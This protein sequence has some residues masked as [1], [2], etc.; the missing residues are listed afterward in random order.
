V[1]YAMGSGIT[2]ESI[3]TPRSG[4]PFLAVTLD[5]GERLLVSP[6]RV[7][8]LAAGDELDA[9][10]AR[11]LRN[12]AY[13]DRLEARLLRL[14][15]VRWRSRGELARRL[16]AWGTPHA[17]AEQLLVRLERRGLLDEERLAGQVSRD[18]RRRGHGSRR[19]AHDLE[20]LEVDDE[21]ATEIV[22]AHER[23]DT[24][25]ATQLILER[26][27]AGPHDSSTCRRAAALLVR[28]G[29][30]EETIERVLDLER[31]G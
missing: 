10:A 12:G 20:R 11:G 24:E 4:S 28:R 26:Y 30:G 1:I 18:L 19:T 8:G 31:F 3:S 13:L 14:L 29:F 22:G 7:I 2:I 9:A 23:D 25:A 17:E 6:E 15:A 21:V 16:A 5:S 27:G